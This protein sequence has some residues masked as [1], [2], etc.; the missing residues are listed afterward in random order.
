MQS[1]PNCIADELD[2]L[3]APILEESYIL[4]RVKNSGDSFYRVMMD[5]DESPYLDIADIFKWLEIEAECD[6]DR[7]Y[8]QAI[9]QP[10]GRIFWIDGDQNL[11]GNSDSNESIA[12]PKDSFFIIENTVWLKW[13]AW[14][15]WLPATFNWSIDRYYLGVDP[16]FK[17]KEERK[18][19]RKKSRE[20]RWSQRRKQEHLDSIP[21]IT[22]EKE[23]LTAMRYSLN[24]HRPAGDELG[25]DGNYD[26]SIDILDG[27]L[28]WS[29]LTADN[30]SETD[31]ISYWNYQQKKKPS[32]YLFELGNTQ[33]TPSLLVPSVSVTSG[34]RFDANERKQGAGTF[35]YQGHTTP[36]TE[37]DV[38][39]GG[40]LE[41]TLIADEAGIFE[42]KKR[43][44]S[45][46]DRVVMQLFLP[47]GSEE[48]IV[49]QIAADNA[50]LLKPKQWDS[51]LVT[52]STSL[53]Q[54]SLIQ[55]RYGLI[56]N[57]SAGVNLFQIPVTEI[58][59][60]SQAGFDFNWRLKDTINFSLEGF[61]NPEN[62]DY[63]AQLNFTLWQS[64]SLQISTQSI[65]ENSPL[66]QSPLLQ[67]QYATYNKILHVL[68]FAKWRVQTLLTNTPDLNTLFVQTDYRWNRDLN[69]HISL[70]ALDMRED[71]SHIRFSGEAGAVY[72]FT[73]T[74]ILAVDRN[75][76]DASVWSI[77]YRYQGTTDN[78]WTEKSRYLPWRLSLQG[79]R[80]DNGSNLW[81][82]S[83]SWYVSERASAS[84]TASKTGINL[85]LTLRDGLI[86]NK[87]KLRTKKLLSA[88]DS[89]VQ[90][91]SYN[92]LNLGIVEG[93]VKTPPS[94]GEGQDPLE[95]VVVRVDTK[96]GITDENGYFHISGLPA[97]Q[98]F[99]I[100]IDQSTIDASMASADENVIVRLRPTSRLKY[101]PALTWTA[102][103]DGVLYTD[104]DIP[105]GLLVQVIL[106]LD[107]SIA[108]Q[109]AIEPDGFFMIEGLT[110]NQ[111]H[112]IVLGVENPP[113][114]FPLEI[115]NGSDWV[116]GLQI[117]WLTAEYIQRQIDNNN[118]VSEEEIIQEDE[119]TQ[120]EEIE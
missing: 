110:P 109:G 81:G 101:N 86:T 11:Y 51:R 28:Q 72:Q 108:G 16:H 107:N 56:Q 1:I 49:I 37:V 32:F 36:G 38:L 23:Y 80:P 4:L 48:E 79:T 57:I 62:T 68:H 77:K 59:S 83:L 2:D 42:I 67:Y 21:A 29:G 94:P 50:L 70:D 60:V 19:D 90:R 96:Q 98:R 91:H 12:L 39:I 106:T 61:N 112:L 105:P 119:I 111:Y 30:G 78:P 6:I 69:F 47:D 41:D 34:M 82:L 120:E 35:Q 115:P 116:S 104:R 65:D 118:S 117:D 15:T 113:P 102:G 54:F 46:G 8:C 103:I 3:E 66:V 53:G 13:D 25:F 43:F 95:G 88:T 14:R 99:S 10:S 52:G 75:I 92:D 40:F 76:S 9:M 5:I 7:Q 71:D 31:V 97:H 44:V 89:A 55:A 74:N 93:Y 114:P 27:N 24:L 84:I 33:Y 87:Q 73:N 26:V 100:R 63:S 17:S 58:T 18:A 20:Y 22:P 45:S 85:Q 64:Q